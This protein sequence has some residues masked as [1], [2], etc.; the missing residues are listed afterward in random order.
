MIR[1]G[2]QHLITAKIQHFLRVFTGD[3][4]VL[5]LQYA[6]CTQ[7]LMACLRNAWHKGHHECELESTM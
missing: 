2:T 6:D 4:E 3:T 5:G 7:P 1:T